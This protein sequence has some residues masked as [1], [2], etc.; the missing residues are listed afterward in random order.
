LRLAPPTGEAYTSTAIG[1]DGAVYAINNAVLFCCAISP[2]HTAAAGGAPLPEQA[3]SAPNGSVAFETRTWASILDLIILCV[4]LVIA[5][6]P[7][8]VSP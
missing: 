2:G 7:Q 6:F 5:A 3:V 1:P 4:P 8:F